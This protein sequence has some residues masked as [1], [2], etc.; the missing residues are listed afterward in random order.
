MVGCST[1]CS[2]PAVVVAVVVVTP[3]ATRVLWLQHVGHHADVM[4]DVGQHVAHPPTAEAMLVANQL[5]ALPLHVVT[6]A[7]I[8]DAVVA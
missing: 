4:L 2:A 5:V 3:A 1:A 8:Q 6:R 7:V